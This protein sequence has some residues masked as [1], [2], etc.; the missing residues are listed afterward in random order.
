VS[1]TIKVSDNEIAATYQV[2]SIATL[3]EINKI[4]YA[5][6]VLLDGDAA[7]QDFAASNESLFIPG[8]TFE[9]LAGYHSDNETIFKGI[10]IKHAIKI[11][12]SHSYLIVECKDETV[13]MTVGKKSKYF[14]DAKDSDVAAEIIDTYGFD[15]DIEDTNITYKELVQFDCADWDFLIS[16][17]EANGKVC[18][19]DDGKISV[20]APAIQTD[21]LF[22]LTYGDNIF[23][24]DAEIDAR[25]QLT[26][27]HSKAWNYSDQSLTEADANEPS[28]TEEG[29][30]DAADINDVIAIDPFILQHSGKLAQDELQVWADA[31]LMKNRFAKIRG[32]VKFQGLAGIKPSDTIRLNG[33][34]DRFNGMVFISGVRHE[35]SNGNWFT[36][37]QFGLSP[38]WFAKDESVNSFFAGALLPAIRG[39]HIG[40]VTDLEDPDGEDRVRVRIPVISADDDGVWSR[41]SS[42]DA[43]NSRGMFFRPEINDEVLVGFI[44]DDPRHPAIIG[45][46]NSS[47]KPAPIKA[48]NQNNQKGY[49]SREG[50]K[51]TFDDENKSIVIETPAGKK[52]TMDENSGVV[53]LEDENNNAITM[54]SNGITIKSQNSIEIS[55]TG[56]LK[57]EGMNVEINA[58]ANL[59]LSSS[60][61]A[62]LKGSIVQIN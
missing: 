10:I 45:M 5:K 6:I 57:L 61:V 59:K 7:S 20:S 23:D 38:Q 19:V 47:A 2:I 27:V 54:D 14:A 51:I 48:S 53:S 4:P 9:I 21:P 25:N 37:L 41:V 16:R 24:F 40:I 18:V 15:K 11:R 46:L 33:V 12:N 29:N 13:K 49:T 52:I 32:R 43:G 31:Q 55:A 56:D 8:N 62:A 36:D 30:L 44:N 1:T 28:I 58:N 22:D 26:A 34:G 35:I 17:M 50:L 60:G 3:K 39:L 42:P